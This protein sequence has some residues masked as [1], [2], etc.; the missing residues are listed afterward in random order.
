MMYRSR[1]KRPTTQLRRKAVRDG[2]RIDAAIRVLEDFG[3]RR[4]PLK[5]ALADWARGARYAG[6]KDRAFISG[7]ALD[8]LR[9]Q[10]SLLAEGGGLRGAVAICLRRHWEWPIVRIKEAY[11]EEPHGPDP[12]TEEE[13]E[14]L[15]AAQASLEKKE[16]H[17]I[18]PHDAANVPAFTWPFFSRVFQ[19]PV[20][21]LNA[22]CARAPVDIR[23]NALKAD[24]EKATKA[25]KPQGVGAAPF[26]QMG[27][28]F[29]PPNAD[30]RA[31]SVMATPAF[32]KGWVEVQDEGSHIAALAAGPLD[33][34]QVLD[35][36]AGGGGKT[37]ALAAMM[38]NR[39]QVYAY[40]QDAHRLAPIFERL[41]RAGA[42]N[43]QVLSPAEGG[44]LSNLAGK[45][46][47]V[48][49][50]APCT[51]SGTWRRH[52]DTKWRLTP[53]QVERRM[54]EQDEVLAAAAQYVKPD[55]HLLYV[56]CSLFA[57]ENEDRVDAFLEKHDEFCLTD[58]VVPIEN[59]GGLKNVLK[60][61]LL[62]DSSTIRLTPAQH[63]TDG[64]TITRLH[65]RIL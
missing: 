56:T 33:G 35:F 6:A 26:T 9:R 22:F 7:L 2:G 20:D 51:G 3:T 1:A 62:R 12:L 29:A 61:F 50:D 11:A 34:A 49:V 52:P 14:A 63:G 28:R 36:C 43:V 37:L 10:A 13:E 30:Q 58:A 59:S 54:A 38:E 25:L 46:D 40:D 53:E 65:R 5:V 48:V 19:E 23:V 42:R 24:P 16:L 39:G 60:P 47:L 44:D 8:V 27:L 45:M 17:A 31:V 64:F 15:Q 32:Q 55:G 57:E 18:A 21:E 41:K 4:V